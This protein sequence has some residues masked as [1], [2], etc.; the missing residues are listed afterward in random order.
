MTIGLNRFKKPYNNDNYYNFN[1]SNNFC[2]DF[3]QKTKNY[4]FNRKPYK[5][6][7]QFQKTV[8]KL[9]LIFI[10]LKKPL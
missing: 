1:F 7:Y 8:L 2:N 4:N 9:L 10:R 5:N 6:Y 3:F